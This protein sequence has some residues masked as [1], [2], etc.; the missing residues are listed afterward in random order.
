MRIKICYFSGTGNSYF[1]AKKIN[2][3]IIDSELVSIVKFLNQDNN[4]IE[5]E[6]IILV[7]PV[8]AL[9]LPIPVRKFLARAKFKDTSY[10]CAI[11]TRW[12]VKFDDFKRIDKLIKP[13]KLN[14]HFIINMGNNDVKVKNY[15]CPTETDFL[16]I[17]EIA[18]IK[19][20]KIVSVIENN[21]DCL[22]KD[23]NYI[24]DMLD[25][26]YKGKILQ[27]MIPKMMTFSEYIG[28][29]NYFYI[30]TKC[31]GCG[32]CSKIC[33]SSKIKLQGN[34]PV[35]QKKTLCYMC[36]ACINYCPTR[37]IEIKS[38]IGVPSFTHVN[39]RYSHPYASY[40]VIKNQK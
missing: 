24:E 32:I 33:L 18:E 37:A 8:Y 6:K 40:M 29:V 39:E 20:R 10:I 19:L 16:E 13:R 34:Q 9:T 17:E 21:E 22:Y 28:G 30:N 35:W 31:S 11:A 38:I 5:G 2:E 1:I 27:W 25:S 12:G 36:Y 14:S 23:D 15:C 26:G 4:L 3:Y 7:F